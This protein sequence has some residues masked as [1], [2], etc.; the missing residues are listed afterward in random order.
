MKTE[1]D[2][3]TQQESV[4]KDFLSS[5][6]ERY[7]ELEAEEDTASEASVPGADRSAKGLEQ[8][9]KAQLEDSK[10]REEEEKRARKEKERIT[11]ERS[12]AKFRAKSKG[13]KEEAESISSLATKTPLGTWKD[14]EDTKVKQSMRELKDWE[15]KVRKI[16]QR[17]TDLI[18]QMAEAGIN[19]E[20]I[21]GWTNT[22]LAINQAATYVREVTDELKSED[23][24]RE[25][26]SNATSVMEK[27]QYP[28]FEGKDEECFA[29]FKVKLEKAFKH[30]QTI[31]SAK[32]TKIKELLRGNAKQHIPDSMDNIDNIYKALERAF[33][34]P[35]RLLNHKEKSLA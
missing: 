31:K 16:K 23:A 21:L 25:L 35:T 26:H 29:D 24:E 18:A 5:L 3:F 9:I 11:K 10:R 15:D 14:V 12:E 22:V 2:R 34:D 7:Y 30:N 17:R 33:G 20:D 8:V 4:I 19:P 13:L 32:A 27:L 1:Q 28:L 6:E